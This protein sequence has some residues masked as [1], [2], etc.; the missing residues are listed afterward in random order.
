MENLSLGFDLRL[1][2]EDYISEVWSPEHRG[3]F[4]L[5]EEIKWPMSVDRSLWPSFLQ[6]HYFDANARPIHHGCSGHRFS[7]LNSK[8]QLPT[9]PVDSL[10]SKHRHIPQ[11]SAADP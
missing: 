11:P 2:A 7:L 9:T 4:L 6:S 5:R 10:Q 3:S 1:R 8:M